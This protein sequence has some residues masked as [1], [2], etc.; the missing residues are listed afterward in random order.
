[1][2]TAYIRWALIFLALTGLLA[3]CG[4]G[5]GNPGTC[6]GSAE[7]CKRGNASAPGTAKTGFALTAQVS[8]LV[9]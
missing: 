7:V 3:A 9:G 4:G 1:M 2:K 5:G 6:Q 8:L